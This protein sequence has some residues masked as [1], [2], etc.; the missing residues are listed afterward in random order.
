M[1]ERRFPCHGVVG[2]LIRGLDGR[3]YFRIYVGSDPETGYCPPRKDGDPWPEFKDYLIDGY[4][5][6]FI[7]IY[8]PDG[9]CELIERADGEKFLDFSL[10]AL[11]K[12]T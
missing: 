11:G 6:P 1:N 9:H 2:C 8:D 10:R 7:K 5:D 4:V 12:E 3:R